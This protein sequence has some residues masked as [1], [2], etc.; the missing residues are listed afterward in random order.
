[1]MQRTSQEF[2]H[3]QA[4]RSFTA[5][6][7]A[8]FAYCP[9]TWWYQQYEPLAEDGT[10]ELFARMVE[11]EHEYG[12]KA[13]SLPEYEM[14]ERLLVRR[15]AFSDGQDQHRAH[16]EEVAELEGFADVEDEQTQLPGTMSAGLRRSMYTIIIAL[17]ALALLLIALAL[18]F[19]IIQ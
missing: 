11:L 10:D 17:A 3:N 18:V 5:S 14:I 6:E 12:P 2:A 19:A 15:G 1:M 7:V 9:L 13:T 16:A 8:E 4:Q